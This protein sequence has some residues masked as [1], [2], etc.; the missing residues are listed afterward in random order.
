MAEKTCLLIVDVQNDFCP[1]G[2]LAVAGAEDII[3]RINRLMEKFDVILA[4]RDMHPEGSRHF[5]KWPVHCVAGTRGADFHPGL[6]TGNITFLLEKGTSG[7]DDGYSDFESTNADLKGLLDKNGITQ[8]Y[9]CGLATDYCVKE[10]V[11]DAL[12]HSFKT[13][14]LTDCI[15]AVNVSPGDGENALKE[16]KEK[17][18][19]L[20]T[21][22][23]L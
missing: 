13:F 21:S 17:G 2:T 4:S 12:K 22:V 3:P 10:T 16:M 8:L 14:V 7:E 9:V 19:A 18:A 5:E 11:L 20:V 1:G 6:H 23:D 15:K